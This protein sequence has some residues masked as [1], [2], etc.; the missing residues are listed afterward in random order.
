MGG[1]GNSEYDDNDS[2]RVQHMA[3]PQ[4]IAPTSGHSRI[5]VPM[6]FDDDKRGKK[7]EGYV[8][9]INDLLFDYKLLLLLLLMNY[10]TYL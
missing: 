5:F 2:P 10:A 8:I 4:H 3:S 9:V 7:N 1:N 6:L